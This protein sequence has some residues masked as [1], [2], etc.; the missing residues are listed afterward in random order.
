[1]LT[2]VYLSISLPLRR[3]ILACAYSS[4]YAGEMKKG[5]RRATVHPIL[6]G[7]KVSQETN[8]LPPLTPPRAPGKAGIFLSS[9]LGSD[10]KK[11]NVTDKKMIRS[12]WPQGAR[13]M[14]M[15]KIV[16]PDKTNID[17]PLI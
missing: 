16:H 11:M 12:S 5:P 3:Q 9:F 13:Y 17:D 4:R 14:M 8:R 10:S 1:M 7:L 2:D 15:N 6:F